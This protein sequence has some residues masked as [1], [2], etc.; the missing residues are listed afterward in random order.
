MDDPL[1]VGTLE[2]ISDLA[3][4][5]QGLSDRH[6]P[7]LKPL[8]EGLAF[9]QFENQRVDVGAFGGLVLEAID[10]ADVRMIE[11]REYVSFA[12]ESRQPLRIQRERSRQHLH[13]DIAPQ[14]SITGAIHLA[15]PAR[16]ERPNQLIHTDAP[17]GRQRRRRRV[18]QRRR[19]GHRRPVENAVDRRRLRQQRF[20]FPPQILVP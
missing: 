16:A 1:L 5:R 10:R 11:R 18:D 4:D 6:R 20:D 13:R 12:L 8:R 2:G 3:R 7:A 15:H 19:E 9:N 14:A 17:A